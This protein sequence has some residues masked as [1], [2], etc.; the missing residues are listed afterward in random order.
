VFRPNFGTNTITDFN[1]INDV[2]QFDRS[3][4]SSIGDLLNHTTNT[5][6]GAVISDG[7]GD[8]VTLSG[9]TLAQLQAHQS[10]FHLVQ[11]KSISAVH[12]LLRRHLPNA[13]Y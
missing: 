3:I 10:E 2:L 8:T 4:F 13:S 11:S 9:V 7:H 12:A 1:I 5:S 6:I